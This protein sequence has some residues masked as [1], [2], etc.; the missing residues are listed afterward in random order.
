MRSD[1]CCLTGVCDG[2][3]SENSRTLLLRSWTS[4]FSF[5]GFVVSFSLSSPSSLVYARSPFSSLSAS[6]TAARSE[7][8]L[9]P[10]YETL[11]ALEDDLGPSI[12]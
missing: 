7:L 12:V 11:K 10:V 8:E 1:V 5:S 6:L 9:I 2:R 4:F 3:L